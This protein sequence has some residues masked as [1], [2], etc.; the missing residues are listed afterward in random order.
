MGS[1]EVGLVVGVVGSEFESPLEVIDC[2][3]IILGVVKGDAV[4]VEN[5]EVVWVA[6]AQVFETRQRIA[7]AAYLTESLSV[8]VNGFSVARI[9]SFEDG[10]ERQ[11]PTSV[12][13][14][15]RNVGEQAVRSK[16]RCNGV[17]ETSFG[18][19]DVSLADQELG[20]GEAIVVATRGQGAARSDLFFIG[21]D[22]QWKD[23]KKY[24][25]HVLL[26]TSV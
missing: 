14:R 25:E 20:D 1:I 8:Q 7:P 18:L 24:E 4:R 11:G 3:G 26:S 23:E 5:V 2:S 22:G 15:S 6:L 21:T 16:G 13:L 12:A 9:E 17:V 19:L 10:R